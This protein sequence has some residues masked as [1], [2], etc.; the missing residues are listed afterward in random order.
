MGGG[1]IR[2]MVSPFFEHPHNHQPGYH[3]T[4]QEWLSLLIK[5]LRT[6]DTIH[7]R[8]VSPDKLQYF[9]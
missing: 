1:G 5:G 6:I 8:N 4:E 2:K 9:I 3:T 7:D